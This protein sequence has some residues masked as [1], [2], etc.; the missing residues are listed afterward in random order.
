MKKLKKSE[1]G[2]FYSIME[3][4]FPSDERRSEKCQKELFDEKCYGVVSN[5][6]VSV[7]IAYWD[8]EKYVYIEHFASE[9]SKRGNGEGGNFLDCFLEKIEKPVVLE[10]EPPNTE[11]AA[12]RIKFYERHGF[13]F[14][15]YFYMQPAYEEGKSPIELKIMT[16][17][18]KISKHEFET[19]RDKIHKKVYKK[20]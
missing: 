7:F 11:M 20:V 8:F 4:A 19:I 14:N 16:Y 9:A 10:V 13:N 2:K 18:E 15:S 17:P 12:R 5:L 1:F 6:E 3:E